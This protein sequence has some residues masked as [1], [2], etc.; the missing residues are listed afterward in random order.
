M[1]AV[2]ALIVINFILILLW[3]PFDLHYQQSQAVLFSIITFVMAVQG[4]PILMIITFLFVKKLYLLIKDVTEHNTRERTAPPVLQSDVDAWTAERLLPLMVKNTLLI[5]I[6]VTASV[7]TVIMLVTL[8]LQNASEGL[9]VVADNSVRRNWEFNLNNENKKQISY[10][11]ISSIISSILAFNSYLVVSLS[12]AS[13]KQIYHRFCRCGDRVLRKR[14][15][16]MVLWSG[17]RERESQKKK[18]SVIK[19]K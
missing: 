9:Y 7:I 2:S 14:M 10:F 4:L 15:R 17:E 16:G 3:L 5:L 6:K 8:R 12:L 13:N 19:N 1:C 11:T 18:Q